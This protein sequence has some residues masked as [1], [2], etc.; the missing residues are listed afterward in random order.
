[1]KDEARA[2][3]AKRVCP[4][5]RA[6]RQGARKAIETLPK[7]PDGKSTV[8]PAILSD[9]GSCWNST[10]FRVVLGENSPSHQRLQPHRHDENGLAK[11]AIAS[12]YRA[13]RRVGRLSLQ[14]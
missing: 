11:P 10:E 12:R 4:W 13:A 7:R 2:V 8:T 3:E 14:A 6:K 5:R 1:M 9:N